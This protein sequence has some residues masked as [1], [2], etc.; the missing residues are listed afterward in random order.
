[1]GKT[2]VFL[3]PSE[4]AKI[5]AKSV[6]DNYILHERQAAEIRLKLR[7]IYRFSIT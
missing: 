5:R 4:I 7:D 2:S 6:L 1:M 3:C